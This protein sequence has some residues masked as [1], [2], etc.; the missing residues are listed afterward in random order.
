MTADTDIDNNPSIDD[1]DG[2]NRLSYEALASWLYVNLR[3]HCDL[4]NVVQHCTNRA[5]LNAAFTT[6]LE[7]FESDVAFAKEEVAIEEE[8]L[9]R[10]R[11]W[12]GFAS[13]AEG[14][15]GLRVIK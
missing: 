3:Y 2:I 6:V 1:I 5:A 4:T 10:A 14:K 15:R 11:G 12:S 9:E 13:I 7:W 8:R